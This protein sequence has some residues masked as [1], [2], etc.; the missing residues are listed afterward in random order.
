M[1]RLAD[2]RRRALLRDTQAKLAGT[3]L[4]RKL[5]V[6]DRRESWTTA[7]APYPRDIPSSRLSCGWTAPREIT[8]RFMKGETEEGSV[9][10][11]GP[12]DRATIA[13]ALYGA[14]YNPAVALHEYA[15]QQQVPYA[16]FSG[17]IDR[18]VWLRDCLEQLGGAE[19]GGHPND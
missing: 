8:R 9:L 11:G 14:P 1:S 6:G 10:S 13:E 15:E 12:M 17:E 4:Q 18:L 5:G 3:R 19:R 7:T 16:E 2:M